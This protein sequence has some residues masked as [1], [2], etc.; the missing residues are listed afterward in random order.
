M[1]FKDAVPFKGVLTRAPSENAVWVLPHD[2]VRYENIDDARTQNYLLFKA[3]DGAK[4]ALSDV[5]KRQTMYCIQRMW[6]CGGRNRLVWISFVSYTHLVT[7]LAQLGADYTMDTGLRYRGKIEND[8]LK[9]SLYLLSLI[10]ISSSLS[11]WISF[12]ILL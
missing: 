2:F 11:S 3:N 10:H 5:Y 12:F 6:P 4:H 8:T 7:A 1:P 9:G